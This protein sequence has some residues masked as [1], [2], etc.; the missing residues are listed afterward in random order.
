[1]ARGEFS[2]TTIELGPCE[3]PGSPHKDGDVAVVKDRLTFGDVRRVAGLLF[4]DDLS[5]TAM[6]IARSI[7][8]WNLV[9]MV[10]GQQRPVHIPTYENG[11]TDL[12]ALDLL[13]VEQSQELRKVV[14]SQKY[15]VQIL[16][17]PEP[18]PNPPSGPSADGSAESTTPK[19]STE[20]SPT[21]S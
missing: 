2:T 17:A 20:T 16:G 3:C 9:E 12:A 19:T 8:S 1:M 13:S 6:M 21:T 15:Q 11:T 5:S 14:D 10:E 7:V 4:S 18:P